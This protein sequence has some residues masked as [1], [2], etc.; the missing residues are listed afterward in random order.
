VYVP[1]DA[2]AT[3]DVRVGTSFISIEQARASLDD[4]A[5]DTLEATARTVRTQWAELLNRV[6]IDVGGRDDEEAKVMRQVFW[7]GIAHSLQV[8]CLSCI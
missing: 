4:E 3:V 2:A 6:S 8:G 7:T 1:Q 5:T